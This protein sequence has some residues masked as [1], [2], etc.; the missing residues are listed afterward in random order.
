MIATGIKTVTRYCSI[1]ESVSYMEIAVRAQK[2]GEIVVGYQMPGAEGDAKAIE[3]VMNPRDKAVVKGFEDFWGHG[4][5]VVVTPAAGK[6]LTP[7]ADGEGQEGEEPAMKLVATTVKPVGVMIFFAS[8]ACGLTASD[9]QRTKAAQ[10][11]DKIK[12]RFSTLES[13]LN[14]IEGTMQVWLCKPLSLEIH[15]NDD[16]ASFQVLRSTLDQ[17]IE[18]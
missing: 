1:G 12:V 5:M 8:H 17:I 14:S 9:L 6:K 4:E 18:L 10:L 15:S 3:T 11:D 13:K 2:Y 16:C 7:G